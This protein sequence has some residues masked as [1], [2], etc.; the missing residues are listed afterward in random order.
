MIAGL[1]AQD[2]TTLA[3]ALTVAIPA[4][5]AAVSA[6]RGRRELRTSNAK[7]TGEVIEETAKTVEVV[8]GQQHGVARELDHVHGR[9]GRIEEKVDRINGRVDRVD[10]N[11]HKHL[12]EVGEGSGALAAWVRKQMEKG[13]S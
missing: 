12:T 4:T 8:Q 2:V 13:D 7:T 3:V 9:L 10:T 6:V 5:I 11:L 1:T